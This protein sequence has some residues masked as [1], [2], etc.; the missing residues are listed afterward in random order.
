MGSLYFFNIPQLMQHFGAKAFVETGTGYGFGVYEAQ[1]HPF[2]IIVS[3]EIMAAEVE[4]LKPAF[5]GDRRVNL[6]AGP[7]PDVLRQLLP[8]IPVPIIFWLDAHFPGAHH[9][10][11]S[12]DAVEEQQIRL[13]LDHE[14]AV[15]KELSA[16]KRDVILIDDLRI[17]ERDNFEW[18]NMSDAGL[19]QVAQ[20]DSRF[21]YTMFQD[22]HN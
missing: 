18:G 6:F 22:T 12:Y 10:D 4:R 3:I 14:L 16:G 8:Q 11:M 5:A 15:I 9:K 1:R 20:Y 17:Y 2:E 19:E 21:L 13:P 7:S